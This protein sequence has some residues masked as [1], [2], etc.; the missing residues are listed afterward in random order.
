MSGYFPRGKAGPE[1]EGQLQIAIA[2]DHQYRMVRV[3]FGKPIAWLGLGEAE[4]RAIAAKLI[5]KADELKQN[6]S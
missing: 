1:D 3:A 2:T 5:E 4:A 6:K